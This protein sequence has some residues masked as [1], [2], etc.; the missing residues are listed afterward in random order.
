MQ[1]ILEFNILNY[2]WKSKFNTKKWWSHNCNDI[3]SSA[4][5]TLGL[6]YF[7]CDIDINQSKL[8]DSKYLCSLV[9]KE[10]KI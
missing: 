10:M 1:I 6:I 2:S 5:N 4:F 8:P 3:V 7:A 9:M